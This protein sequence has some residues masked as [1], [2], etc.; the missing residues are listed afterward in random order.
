MVL[1][2]NFKLTMSSEIRSY[3]M[4]A[5]KA[6]QVD[7][8]LKEGRDRLY[9]A[10]VKLDNLTNMTTPEETAV[11]R[12]RLYTDLHHHKIFSEIEAYR[13]QGKNQYTK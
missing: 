13:I 4:N 1:E 2:D 11:L 10:E 9:L 8:D 12:A 3:L 6:I 5:E 7:G